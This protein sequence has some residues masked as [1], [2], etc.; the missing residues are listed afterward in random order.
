MGIGDWA[1]GIGQG[2]A[3]L[4]VWGWGIGHWALGIGHWKITVEAATWGQLSI[5]SSQLSGFMDRVRIS[6]NREP[7]RSQLTTRN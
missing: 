6:G 3:N 1:W 4:K 5:M 7:A 2:C